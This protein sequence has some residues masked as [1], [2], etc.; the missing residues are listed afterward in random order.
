[1]NIEDALFHTV[2]DYIQEEAGNVREQMI[3]GM[4]QNFKPTLEALN[5]IF[6]S[7]NAFIKYTT[8][9]EK[10]STPG[11]EIALWFLAKKHSFH[12]ALLTKTGAWLKTDGLDV[13][14]CSLFFALTIEG[15]ILSVVPKCSSKNVAES[16]KKPAKRG[17]KKRKKVEE[18]ETGETSTSTLEPG[19]KRSK[20]DEGNDE[21]TPTET[22]SDA[23]TIILGNEELSHAED[24]GNTADEANASIA[25]ELSQKILEKFGEDALHSTP[26][27]TVLHSVRSTRSTTKAP[28]TSEIVNTE[29]EKEITLIK[30]EKTGKF[31]MIS[32]M[33]PRRVL[34]ECSHKCNLCTETFKTLEEM[35]QHR[36]RDHI[37]VSFKC[38]VCSKEFATKSSGDRHVKCHII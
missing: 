30:A 5:E 15:Y 9:M 13:D 7:G 34:R 18:S 31:S 26:S 32:I 14:Q 27:A 3:L 21:K 28:E 8:S 24:L 23:E 17:R 20:S 36:A 38:S 35:R 1:M 37:L 33:L 16:D 11:D 10:R 22:L 12:G 25:S 4:R 2:G 6:L 19:L 29:K